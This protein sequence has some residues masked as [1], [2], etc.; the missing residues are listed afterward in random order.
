MALIKC[1][2][3]GKEISDK[4]SKCQNCGYPLRKTSKHNKNIYM[5]IGVLGCIILISTYFIFKK[6]NEELGYYNDIPWG[7][8]F[9]EVKNIIQEQYSEDEIMI[10]NKSES[11]HI[12][13]NKFFDETVE[14]NRT[15]LECK[16]GLNKVLISIIANNDIFF[17]KYKQKF[18]KLFGEYTIENG[19]IYMDNIKKQNR[20]ST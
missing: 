20:I 6:S 9:D 13:T 16:N 3:C 7:T 5:I 12:T 11:I 8:N 14:D 15:I 2:E 4:A 18:S 17:E 10:M 1:P 19:Y